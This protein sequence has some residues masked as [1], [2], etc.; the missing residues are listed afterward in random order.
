MKSSPQLNVGGHCCLMRQGRGGEVLGNRSGDDRTRWDSAEKW[1]KKRDLAV[2][3]GS[4][5]GFTLGNLGK[6]KKKKQ[7]MSRHELPIR[8]LAERDKEISAGK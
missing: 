4:S 5:R 3:G 1:P 8:I 6:K 7:I 2:P